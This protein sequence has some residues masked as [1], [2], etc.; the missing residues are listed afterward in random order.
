MV[1]ASIFDMFL[2]GGFIAT[3]ESKWLSCC[4]TG[5][6]MPW[7]SCPYPAFGDGLGDYLSAVSYG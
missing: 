5:M 2:L 6:W 3:I 4:Q 1:K 7:S